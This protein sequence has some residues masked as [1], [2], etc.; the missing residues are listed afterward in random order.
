P[1]LPYLLKREAHGRSEQSERFLVTVLAR[2]PLERDS[3]DHG[4][5][6]KAS[7][8]LA[9]GVVDELR[10]PISLVGALR[11]RR[12]GHHP[13][14][15][16]VAKDF[17]RDVMAL[18]ARIAVTVGFVHNADLDFPI[19]VQPLGEAVQLHHGADLAIVVVGVGP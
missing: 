17:A 18:G 6:A 8:R 2:K 16:A 15:W 7:I 4:L 13:Q 9:E 14:V 3:V 11:C 10:Y 1:V 12:A 19:L 5:V